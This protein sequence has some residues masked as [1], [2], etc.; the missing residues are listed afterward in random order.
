M[1]E[2]EKDRLIVELQTDILLLQADVVDLTDRLSRVIDL[3]AQATL[4]GE[5]E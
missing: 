1:N 5:G 2:T 4:E 3:L